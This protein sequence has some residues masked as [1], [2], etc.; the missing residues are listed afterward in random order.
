MDYPTMMRNKRTSW[1]NWQGDVSRRGSWRTDGCKNL[2]VGL[3]CVALPP[4]QMGSLIPLS[5]AVVAA[6]INESLVS[7]TEPGS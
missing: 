7:G 5:A 6:P 3:V 2:D 4:A 1:L